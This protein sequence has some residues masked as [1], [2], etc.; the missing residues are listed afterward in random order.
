MRVDPLSLIPKNRFF[1]P[2]HTACGET[3]QNINRKCNM[4]LRTSHK[5]LFNIMLL[6]PSPS[7]V[8]WPVNQKESQYCDC[9]F[10]YFCLT[11]QIKGFNSGYLWAHKASELWSIDSAAFLIKCFNRQSY[12]ARF[13][14]NLHRHSMPGRLTL[15]RSCFST[16]VDALNSSPM[17]YVADNPDLFS[18][19]LQPLKCNSLRIVF[20]FSGSSFFQDFLIF[21]GLGHPSPG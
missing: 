3:A 11:M 12:L 6:F 16:T 15:S 10:L 5:V 18:Y 13:R 21:L 14:K 2:Y 8:V 19:N 4:T 20:T 9:L 7:K 17:F 1:L